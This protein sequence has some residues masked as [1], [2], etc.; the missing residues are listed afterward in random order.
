MK[1]IFLNILN[2]EKIEK[3]FNIIEKRGIQRQSFFK[4]V[5]NDN[6]HYIKLKEMKKGKGTLT[7]NEEIDTNWIKDILDINS[8]QDSFIFLQKIGLVNTS[9]QEYFRQTWKHKK[10]N[11]YLSKEEWPLLPTVI[12]LYGKNKNDV[13]KIIRDLKLKKMIGYKISDIYDKILDIPKHILQNIPSL[14]FDSEKDIKKHIENQKKRFS[15][16]RR[17]LDKKIVLKSSPTTE[18][19]K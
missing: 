13:N 4:T 7:F 12:K 18:G 10:K 8:Y 6:N 5:L 17:E 2:I 11:V 3:D 19:S 1:S 14:T 9:Y 16:K 15:N